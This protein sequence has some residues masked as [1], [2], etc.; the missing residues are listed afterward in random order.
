VTRRGGRTKA[1]AGTAVKRTVEIGRKEKS[2]VRIIT[3]CFIEGAAPLAGLGARS[4]NDD[5]NGLL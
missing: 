1:I 5:A 3:T 4:H 2:G